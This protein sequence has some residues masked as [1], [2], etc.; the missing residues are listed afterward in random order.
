M[1]PSPAMRCSPGR[2]TRDNNHKRGHSFEG[3]L[4]FKERDEDLALFSE[5]Q[6][7]ERETF[8]LQSSDDLE[9]TFCNFFFCIFF[10]FRYMRLRF[11]LSYGCL[12]IFFFFDSFKVATLFGYQTWDLDSSAGRE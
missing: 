4:F 9:A 6:T 12:L 7:R 2:G 3:G 8:L 5:M 10:S 1:P 11:H